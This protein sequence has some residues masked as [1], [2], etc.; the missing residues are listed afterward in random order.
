VAGFK[1]GEFRHLEGI[2]EDLRGPQRILV[3]AAEGSVLGST[4]S[5]SAENSGIFGLTRTNT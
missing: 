4:G 3:W 5:D 2:L 1:D